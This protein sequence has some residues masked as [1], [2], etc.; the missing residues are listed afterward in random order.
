MTQQPL[1]LTA[2]YAGWADYQHRLIE[3]IA[4]LSP[5]Q[6]ALPVSQ[7]W[8]IGMVAQHMVANRVWWFDGWMG[9]GSP[10]LAPIM[11]WDPGDNE[12]PPVLPPAELVGGLQ[13]TWRMIADAL[14]RRT[15]TEIG[16][17]FPPPAFL[18]E[19]ER[20]YWGE[21]TLQWIIWYV[22]QHEI[23]HGGEL[24]LVLGNYGLEGIYGKA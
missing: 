5:E 3:I 2:F 19:R 20:N 4:P 7:H 11:R 15:T 13:A 17:V 21:R 16:Q 9:E 23:H 22:L 24:S 6:L 10:D 14:A 18:S 1:S 8:S 12:A